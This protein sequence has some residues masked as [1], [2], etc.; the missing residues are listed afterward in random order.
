MIKMAAAARNT[1]SIVGN[2]KLTAFNLRILKTLL[3]HGCGKAVD[4]PS[5]TCG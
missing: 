5:I 1:G 3:I 2:F 4:E